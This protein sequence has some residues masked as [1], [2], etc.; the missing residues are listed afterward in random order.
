MRHHAEGQHVRLAQTSHVVR[1]LPRLSAGLADPF[2]QSRFARLRLA[3]I[4]QGT[5][6]IVDAAHATEL[7]VVDACLCVVKLLARLREFR[8]KTLVL[9]LCSA[10]RV[11]L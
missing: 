7:E 9:G 1:L 11:Q 2:V 3:G 8:A 4:E 10:L 5:D 6:E